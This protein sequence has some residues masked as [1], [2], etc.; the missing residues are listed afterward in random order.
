MLKLLRVPAKPIL[1]QGTKPPTA[2]TAKAIEFFDQ[3]QM[4]PGSKVKHLEKIEE[5]T[6]IP[7]EEMLFFDDESRNRDVEQLGVVMW[8]V[9][10]GVCND[11]IDKGVLSWRKRNKR[12][13]S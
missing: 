7:F 8:L 1:R 5:E 3:L 10:D 12:E 11:E 13:L 9:R 4:Y 6:G 2:T